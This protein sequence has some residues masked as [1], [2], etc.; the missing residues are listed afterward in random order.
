VEA[1]LTW[2][3]TMMALCSS[4]CA[5]SVCLASVGSVLDAA[6]GD[7]HSLA[8][9]TESEDGR[10]STLYAH[11][12]H[13]CCVLMCIDTTA[14]TRGA[15]MSA[16]SLASAPPNKLSHGLL[17]LCLALTER[18]CFLFT[19]APTAALLSLATAAPFSGEATRPTS[20]QPADI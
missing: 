2:Y 10:G 9:L 15:A 6:C 17:L 8:L 4:V 13:H 3:V 20:E 18:G 1:F 14:D 11:F 16:V 5:H 7:S 12:V 19:L